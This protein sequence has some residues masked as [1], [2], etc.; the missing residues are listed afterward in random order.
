MPWACTSIVP[1][2]TGPLQG[3]AIKCVVRVLF[4]LLRR[5][6]WGIYIK[7]IENHPLSSLSPRFQIPPPRPYF[8]TVSRS[9]SDGHSLCLWSLC[10]GGRPVCFIAVSASSSPRPTDRSFSI[11]RNFCGLSNPI[12]E[13]TR[14][15]AVNGRSNW[16]SLPLPSIYRPD[17]SR[18]SMHDGTSKK[19][20]P[21]QQR[22]GVDI[23][24]SSRQ[25]TTI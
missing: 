14:S 7:R 25:C 16:L 3:F 18:S 22:G 8:L 5:P 1:G 6:R 4:T 12:D 24:E 13:R 23:P 20:S 2:S 11:V 10:R 21:K 17:K 15:F 9:P 19:W